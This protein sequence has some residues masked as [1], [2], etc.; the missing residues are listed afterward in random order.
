LEYRNRLIRDGDGKPVAFQGAARDVTKRIEYEKALKESEEKYK[1][2]VRHAPAGIFEV[3]L[4]T[5]TFISIND[6]ICDYTGYTAEALMQMDPLDLF[7]DASRDRAIQRL[8]AVFATHQD[9]VPAEY[10][11]VGKNGRTFR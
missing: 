1:E 10:Q 4:V 9:P 6:V 11:I 7:D 3:D 8:E 2:L 5:M